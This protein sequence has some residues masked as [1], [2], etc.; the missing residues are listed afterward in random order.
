VPTLSTRLRVLSVAVAVLGVSTI[1]VPYVGGRTAH[2][3]AAPGATVRASVANES[4]AEAE[5]GGYQQ[6]LSTD[7]TAVA[8]TSES[9]LDDLDTRGYENVYVRDLARQR[10]VLISRGQFTRPA[11]GDPKPGEIAANQHSYQ[12]TISADGRYVAFVT[13]A[14]NLV[15][16]DA[17][18][19]RDIL[20]CDRDPDDDGDFDEPG[21]G[22]A[23]DYRY[24]RVTRPNYGKAAHLRS[25]S[26]SW[27]KL[28]DDATRIVW[29]D[30]VYHRDQVRTASL[31]SPTGDGRLVPP[32]S[33]EQVYSE[34]PGL[35]L[36]DQSEPDVSGDGRHIVLRAYFA[37]PANDVYISDAPSST[38]RAIM[39][40]EAGTENTVRVDLVPGF[41]PAAPRYL[42]TDGDVRRPVLSS[43]GTVVAFSAEVHGQPGVYV[44]H[45]E[46]S[47]RSDL[48]SRDNA[49]EPV[50]GIAPGLSGD[51]RLVAFVTDD[52]G[53]HDGVDIPSAGSCLSGG[54]SVLPPPSVYA[55]L[56]PS[57]QVVVRD[58][59]ADRTAR[60]PGALASPARSC[61][62]D[63]PEEATCTGDGNTTPYG[64]ERSPTLSGN[65]SRIAYDSEATDLVPDVA[66]RNGRID[67]FVRT[68]R[69]ELRADPDPLEFGDV[70]AGDVVAATVRFDHVGIGPLVVESVEVT[71][72][73]AFR[74][75][76]H[77]CTAVLQQTGSCWVSVEFAPTEAG[78][79]EAVL[80]ASEY[81]VDLRGNGTVDPP[82]VPGPARFTAGPDPLD[83]GPR[84]PLSKGPPST[85]TVTNL[86]GTELTVTAVTVEPPT[87]A[88]HYSVAATDCTKVIAGGTCTVSV[89][90]SPRS[91]GDQPA[92]LRFSS[93]A[94]GAPHLVGLRGSGGEPVLTVSPAVSPPGRVVS[95]TGTGFAP[96]LPVVVDGAVLTAPV[97]AAANGMFRASLLVL[98]NSPIGNRLVV[99]EVLGVPA[100]R[101]GSML[102]VVTPTVSP[103][104]FVVRG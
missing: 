10:T 2:A 78:D 24:F 77:S 35:A 81:T 53:A 13:T 45:L 1:V 34:L 62:S 30:E 76:E 23:R 71:G 60:P 80:H 7:G 67:V 14:D 65:G 8:F 33:I 102:L 20:V 26:P 6:E 16:D 95:L 49:G 59:V 103:A 37:M 63:Q 29:Q 19:H 66:D 96:G 41:D 93:D 64:A 94:P 69:P 27:P 92:V 47:V 40:T 39:R 52:P 31:A 84:L 85:L 48:V 61:A 73:D 70:K 101:D 56:S 88:A 75:G 12:P 55:E 5:H 91:P 38:Q 51:G 104:D 11:E 42:G 79:R 3:A 98:P 100:V 46:Q 18:N 4:N 22:V 82:A 89:R 36:V 43:D 28:S 44:V 57:C 54:D 68:F 83:F 90:F 25:D 72:S 32:A 17:D 58:L 21:E 86:G 87:A 97:V 50:D 15:L 9:R 99:A 74:L